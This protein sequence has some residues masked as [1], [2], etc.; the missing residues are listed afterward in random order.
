MIRIKYW[1]IK[2]F[3]RG[4]TISI[5]VNKVSAK[6]YS[7]TSTD[8]HQ[9]LNSTRDEGCRQTD[10][11]GQPIIAPPVFSVANRLKSQKPK[12]CKIKIPTKMLRIICL[13]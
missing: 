3:S 13:N 6:I 7:V 5:C 12:L 2:S 9:D 11:H 10:I 4:Y 8:T 1:C